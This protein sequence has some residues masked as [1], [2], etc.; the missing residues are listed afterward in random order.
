[1]TRLIAIPASLWEW[2]DI[3]FAHALHKYDLAAH[4]PHPP[5]FPVFVAMTRAAYWIFG[6]EHR[7]LTTVAFIFA[8]L[9]APALYYFYRAVFEDRRIAFAGAMLASF[10]P[11]VWVHSGAGRSDG[12]AFTLGIIG[13]TLVIHG[14]H[15]QRSLIAGCAVF[16]L[17]MGVRTTL[18]PVMG[19]VIALVFITRLRRRE[20]LCVVAAVA[21]GTLCVLIWFLPLVYHVSWSVYRFVMD[22]HSQYI[23]K[24][25]TIFSFSE[26]PWLFH[27][28]RFRRFF[29]H[30]WGTKWVMD[31]IYAFSALGLF[32]LAFKRQWKTIGLMAIAFLPYL[33]FTVVLNAPLGG[34]LY[35]LPYI[36]FFT[37][38]AACGLI[39]VPGSLFY[40]G[41][42]RVLKNSGLILAICL[43]MTIAGWTYPII[44]LLHEEVSPPVRAFDYLKQNLDPE[45]DLLLY[46]GLFLPYVSLYLPN[47]RSI[48]Q[49]EV[50]EPEANLIWSITDHPH[51]ISLTR[52]PL[53]GLDGKHFNWESSSLASR[54]FYKLSLERFF[55]AHI[56]TLSKPRGILFLSG[57]YG[58]EY[59]EKEMW[60][61]ML[62]TGKVALRNLAESM[63]LRIRGSI[64]D[65]PN[66]DRHPTIVLRM[67]GTEINRITIDGTEFD[68]QLTIKTNPSLLW[69]ILSIE[70][71]LTFTGGGS[72]A[73]DNQKPRLKCFNFE[74][75]PAPGALPSNSDPDQYL[76]T[77]WGKLE[78]DKNN[79]WRWTS[80]SSI[81]H[82]PAIEGNGR[83]DL[84]MAVSLRNGETEGEV[85]VELGGQVL[86]KFRPPNDYFIKSYKIPQS[87][88]RNAKLDLKISLLND[89]ARP[90]A[91]QIY[92]MGWRPSEKN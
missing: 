92:Y 47:H 34:P 1:M 71:D 3:L 26:D 4:S 16:G 13:L 40:S 64:L 33:I 6:D 46:D 7:A 48:Q 88:H 36:P 27:F 57:W 8:S 65:L 52:D 29:V 15:S 66:S 43:T 73:S 39:L 19:P 86:E 12:V 69:S 90:N 61:W 68:H 10:A 9:V 54:R 55:G 5:G 76:G 35:S 14:F 67:N 85:K 44:R 60:R 62:S 17:A 63:T 28:Y 78:N 82:L 77:G 45:R 59:N 2:D 87:L 72:S 83:L 79:Y 75:L 25:D 91:I 89:V 70:V 20:W 11:N 53:L 30:I 21:V 32:S 58:F 74:W 80:G 24:T 51:I 81:T 84:K 49:D 42:W 50:L 31:I 22:Q 38:L 23:L 56:T 41:H 18:L 37:G